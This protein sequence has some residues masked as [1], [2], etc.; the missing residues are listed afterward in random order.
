MH[1]DRRRCTH[2]GACVEVCYADA[3]ELVGRR[4]S[5]A[6]VL[7]EIE[8]DRPFYDQSG[9]GV[10]F[11]GGEPL[12]QPAFLRLLLRACREREIHTAVDT[13][14]FAPWETI[15]SIGRDVAL[16]LYDV[17]LVDDDHHRRFTGVSNRPILENLRRLSAWVPTEQAIRLRVPLIPGVNDADEDIR[18]IGALV[19]SLP[20]RHRLDLLPYHHIAV[21]KYARLGRPYALVDAHPIPAERVAEVAAMLR[22]FD[23]DVYVGG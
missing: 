15:E 6:Q 16:F 22:E 2:C 14:G 19:A 5:V 17:K 4:V 9:G 23:L 18:Q 8:S 13:C 21:E 3:R 7:A 10:T 1:T 20:R 12:A 11:S